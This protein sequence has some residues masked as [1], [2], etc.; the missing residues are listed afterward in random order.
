MRS[1]FHGERPV[2]FEKT[3]R[4]E[5][6]RRRGGGDADIYVFPLMNL[7]YYVV[8]LLLVSRRYSVKSCFFFLLF[9]SLQKEGITVNVGSLSLQ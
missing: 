7:F 2:A 4:V 8:I 5:G 3:F 1:M 9:S 6:F